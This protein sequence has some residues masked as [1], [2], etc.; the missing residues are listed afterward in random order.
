MVP[1][2]R[3]V[4]VLSVRVSVPEQVMETYGP[5]ATAGFRKHPAHPHRDTLADV[6]PPVIHPPA[7][8]GG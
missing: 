4:L 8:R 1:D 5:K 2:S 6:P 7:F 3:E